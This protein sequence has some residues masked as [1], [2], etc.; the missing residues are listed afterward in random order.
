MF[1]PDFA[2]HPHK[3]HQIAEKAFSAF[4]KKHLKTIQDSTQPFQD[5]EPKVSL[6]PIIQAGQFN[7]K[8]EEE[9]FELLFRH[10]N[11]EDLLPDRPLVDLT[12]GYFALYQPYQ[13]LILDSPNVDVQ[14][15]AASPKVCV[16][17]NS[18]F[19]TSWSF[20]L[21]YGFTLG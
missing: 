10:A 3:I 12:S 2:T 17:R 1:W 18:F 19:F 20:E 8:E 16:W 5:A 9:V 13:K 21:M 15:I 6:F 4:Q 14:V 7:I 11:D